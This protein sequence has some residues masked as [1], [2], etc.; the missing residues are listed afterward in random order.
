MYENQIKQYEDIRAGYPMFVVKSDQK[1][2]YLTALRMIRKEGT[3]EH[4]IHFFFGSAISGMK[5]VLE[6]KSSNSIRFSSFLF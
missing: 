2:A 4:L 5:E 6:Q 1:D 3:D